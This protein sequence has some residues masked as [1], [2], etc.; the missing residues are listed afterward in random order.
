M[1][2]R[3]HEFCFGVNILVC[4]LICCC[5]VEGC[6]I[7]LDGFFFFFLLLGRVL[8]GKIRNWGKKNKIGGKG[9]LSVLGRPD[10]ESLMQ[11]Q[12][13]EASGWIYTVSL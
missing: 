2:V 8:C 4:G 1:F 9:Y 6:L 10:V 7:P 11:F 3:N 13:A 5:G 12:G